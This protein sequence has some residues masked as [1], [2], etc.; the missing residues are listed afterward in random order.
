MAFCVCTSVRKSD[1]MMLEILFTVCFVW[2]QI[3]EGEKFPAHRCILSASCPYFHIM[4]E[5]NHFVESSQHE[6]EL[7]YVHKEALAGILS[8]IYGD[9]FE[10]NTNNVASILAVAD[11]LM[12]SEV[13]YTLLPPAMWP[14]VWQYTLLPPAM[15]PVF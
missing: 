3:A 7:K 14:V 4:F 15:W 12:L 9:V 1:N 5:E 6:V 11:L 8:L 2:F 10:M 13:E